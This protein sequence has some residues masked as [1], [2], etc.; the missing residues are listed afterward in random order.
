M[1]IALG[2]YGPH[3]GVPSYNDNCI[4]VMPIKE[5]GHRKSSTMCSDYGV[6]TLLASLY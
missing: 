2:G 5:V 1:H 4:H 6:T 3:Q